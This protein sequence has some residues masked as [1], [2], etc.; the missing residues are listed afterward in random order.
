MQLAEQSL[1]YFL[2]FARYQ[3]LYCLHLF[4]VSLD[5]KSLAFQSS[6]K[7]YL[8]LILSLDISFVVPLE[9]HQFD[10]E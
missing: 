3:C 10:E 5:E 6:K 7:S 2:D 4:P 8:K 9:F 1:K